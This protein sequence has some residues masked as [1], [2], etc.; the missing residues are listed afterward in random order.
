MDFN[1]R[2]NPVAAPPPRNKDK[3][4]PS[5][6][7]LSIALG[8]LVVPTQHLDNP[9]KGLIY[10]PVDNPSQIILV[11]R[12]EAT[13]F[14]GRRTITLCNTLDAVEENLRKIQ[15]RG[16]TKHVIC[17][18]KHTYSFVGTQPYRG[19]T[20]IHTVP[21]ALK[22]TDPKNQKRIIKLFR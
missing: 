21:C 1:P 13:I 6:R 2:I 9:I 11:P 16:N 22:E 8:E 17:E 19:A 15:E 20:G 7:V 10:K 14:I 5:T 3:I 4:N 12:I 18:D